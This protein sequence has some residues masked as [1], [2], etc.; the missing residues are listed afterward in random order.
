MIAMCP[1]SVD[2]ALGLSTSFALN[3][4]WPVWFPLC[5]WTPTRW[6]RFGWPAKGT[7][8]W[9]T[10]RHSNEI[11]GEKKH[12]KIVNVIGE[13]KNPATEGDFLCMICI[14]YSL[15]FQ[16]RTSQ[17][18]FEYIKHNKCVF[19]YPERGWWCAV[20]H[21]PAANMNE[22]G[23]MKKTHNYLPSRP[24]SAIREWHH[25]IRRTLSAVWQNQ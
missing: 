13:K 5:W 21:S 8:M 17:F 18:Y 12:S 11:K 15:V 4:R 6:I 10:E 16:R 24:C 14:V 19:A 2:D 9:H 20:A 7:R 23:K 3:V 22:K 1:R 25:S